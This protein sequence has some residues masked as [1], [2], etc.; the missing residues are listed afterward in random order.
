MKEAFEALTTTETL[1]FR[2]LAPFDALREHIIPELA[3]RNA[4][5]PLSIWSAACSTGQE[6]YRIAMLFA[7]HHHQI[8]FRIIGTDIAPTVLT[9]AREGVYL[10][11]EVNRGLP[12]KLLIKYFRQKT[13]DWI[14]SD[15]LRACVDFRHLNLTASWAELPAYDLILMR[16]VL[17]YFDV[18]TRRQI[19]SRVK[20]QLRPGGYVSLGGADPPVQIDPSF[21]PVTFGRAT[22]YR[23]E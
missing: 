4:G 10:Q 7:E 5:H 14:I 23:I 12:A 15:A 17:I 8:P 21:V 6:A 3:Q 13:G 9:K 1:F 22:F 20:K 2:D 16:N 11:H 19:L 18:E